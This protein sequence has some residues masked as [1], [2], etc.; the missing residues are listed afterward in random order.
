M[1]RGSR[2]RR[3]TSAGGTVCSAARGQSQSQTTP[4]PVLSMIHGAHAGL[5]TRCAHYFKIPGL[6][7]GDKGER[8][9]TLWNDVVTPVLGNP[10]LTKPPCAGVRTDAERSLIP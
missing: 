8:A 2:N 3:A 5:H 7:P 9:A 10:S 6:G 1:K 4:T